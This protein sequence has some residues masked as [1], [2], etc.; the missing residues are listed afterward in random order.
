MGKGHAVPP[1]FP[2]NLRAIRTVDGIGRHRRLCVSG[3]TCSA[4]IGAIPQHH[5]A[6]Q[7]EALGDR[8]PFETDERR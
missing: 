7:V 8:R 4:L 6:V 1:V 2:R 5:V 3:E